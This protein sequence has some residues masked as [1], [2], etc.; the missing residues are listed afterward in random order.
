MYRDM[1]RT[2]HQ[3]PQITESDYVRVT[4]TGGAPNRNLARYVASL[5]PATG[6]DVDAMLVLFTLL[7]QR[8]VTA[9]GLEPVLQKRAGEVETVLRGLACDDVAMLEPTRQ[10]ARRRMATYRLREHV[11]REL[12]TAV[13]YRRRI[14]D[15]IDRK[16][17]ATV[18][19]LGQITNGVVQHSWTSRWSEHP[20]SSLTLSTGRSW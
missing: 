12:G 6:D 11:L 19:E 15:E 4:L 14:A 17:A 13:S 7:T 3:S 20:G 5:P 16:V 9:S 10:T 1:I 18:S 8:T 2:G